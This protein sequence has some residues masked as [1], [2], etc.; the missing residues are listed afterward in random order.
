[1]LSNNEKGIHGMFHIH[2]W[3]APLL[4]SQ[5]NSQ[6]LLSYRLYTAMSA[7]NMKHALSITAMAILVQMLE[8]FFGD[9]Y[10]SIGYF[11]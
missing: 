9:G 10:F 1:M 7:L 3:P 8:G 2:L 11:Q 6:E 5:E 4:P